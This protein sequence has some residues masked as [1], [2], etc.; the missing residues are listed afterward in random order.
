MARVVVELVVGTNIWTMQYIQAAAPLIILSPPFEP[1]SDKLRTT[2][3]WANNSL[4]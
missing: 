1:K 3:R 4:L 2:D